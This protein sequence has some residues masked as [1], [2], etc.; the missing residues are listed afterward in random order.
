MANE[1]R[2]NAGELRQEIKICDADLNQDGS[3]GVVSTN[4]TPFATT[5]AKIGTM[6]GKELEA[7]QQVVSEVTHKITIRYR[8]GIFARQVV[9][10]GDR[11]FTIEYVSNVN[12]R[13]VKLELLCIER[14]D[15]S[16]V[17][18]GSQ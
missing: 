13:N 11:F 7:A 8:P 17:A 16:R 18:G 12:E 4:A 10:Y 2:I 15:S 14:N 1:E 3:G 9:L 5:R 6:V